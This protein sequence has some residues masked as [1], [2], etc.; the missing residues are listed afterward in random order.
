MWFIK[1][2]LLVALT[3]VVALAGLVMG[4][5]GAMALQLHPEMPIVGWSMVAASLGF[6]ACGLVCI[7]SL[8]ARA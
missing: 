5:A 1:L 2:M 4:W 8:A 7:L 3:I 6:D